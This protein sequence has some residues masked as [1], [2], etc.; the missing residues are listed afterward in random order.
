[1]P[2]AAA[3]ERIIARAELLHLVQTG[4]A[5][6]ACEPLTATSRG[7]RRDVE[8]PGMAEDE[9]AARRLL[10]PQRLR[11]NIDKTRNLIGLVET[12]LYVIVGVLLVFFVVIAPQGLIGLAQ[13]WL[14]FSR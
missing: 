7:L 9:R 5:Y 8:G 3:R 6:A 13:K 11:F 12:T 2:A 4:V 14:R 1:M 10:R